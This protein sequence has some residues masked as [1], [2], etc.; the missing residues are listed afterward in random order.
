[1]YVVNSAIAA[2]P[3]CLRAISI[4]L[5]GMTSLKK[6]RVVYATGVVHVT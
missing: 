5:Y 1:V 6:G 3:R 4:P 2:T